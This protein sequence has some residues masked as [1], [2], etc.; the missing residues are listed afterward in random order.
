[1][2]ILRIFDS[3][4]LVLATVTCVFAIMPAHADTTAIQ[5][6]IAYGKTEQ[7]GTPTPTAPVPIMTNNGVLKVSPNLFVNGNCANGTSNWEIPAGIT[8]TDTTNYAVF[9]NTKSSAIYIRIKNDNRVAGHVYAYIIGGKTENG[10]MGWGS[11]NTKN[12]QPSLSSTDDV[13][14]GI[15]EFPVN[16]SGNA[17][18]NIPGGG[19]FYLNKGAGFR[20]YDLT[21]LGLDT[22]I[23][24]PSQVINYFGNKYQDKT[25]VYADGMVETIRDAAG[26]KATAQMLLSV[27]DYKDEQNIT[28]GA[29]TRRVGVKVLD[30]TEDWRK[31]VS[32]ADTRNAFSTNLNFVPQS[33][34]SYCTH[35]PNVTSTNLDGVYLGVGMNFI[36]GSS[37]N[38]TTA[39]QFKAWLAEQYANGTPVIVVYPLAEPTTETVTAQSLTTAPVRQALG[40]IMDMPIKTILTDNTEIMSGANELIKIATTKYNEESFEDVQG[41]LT[42]VFNAVDTVVTQTMTQAQQ[43]DQIATNKQT[44]P[45]EGC[46]PFKKC[47][48]V[49]DE[50]GTPHWYEIYDPINDFLRP[51]LAAAGLSGNRG[52]PTQTTHTSGSDTIYDTY[53]GFY[54]TNNIFKNQYVSGTVSAQNRPFGPTTLPRCDDNATRTTMPTNAGICYNTGGM[55]RDLTD[56][57]EDDAGEWAVV[58]NGNEGGASLGITPGVVYGVAK[59]TT[60]GQHTTQ[61]TGDVA[62][63]SN[64]WWPKKLTEYSNTT[65]SSLIEQYPNVVDVFN[66]LPNPVGTDEKPG[67]PRANY[68]NCW[69]KMTAIGVPGAGDDFAAQAANGTIMSVSGDWVFDRVIGDLNNCVGQCAYYCTSLVMVLS[70]SRKAVFTAN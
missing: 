49:E 14:A 20:M 70:K 47:L 9:E 11:R 2:K 68:R 41:A 35:L 5:S 29:I 8:Y 45:D 1:M 58:Y 43:I 7:N 6:V 67:Y 69:C 66:T 23:T 65:L 10:I 61:M 37:S 48:L 12:F 56:G 30:G 17:W 26:H 54:K 39:E 3:L 24:T 36:L 50:D 15:D 21:A 32:L 62:D 27:G 19:K 28:T 55:F 4:K 22:T 51:I 33:K 34:V 42:G 52:A 38:I 57:P 44:R 64:Y 60:V 46:P 16:G 18:V 59:C 63:G 13:H 25:G 31:N 53:N 40:A